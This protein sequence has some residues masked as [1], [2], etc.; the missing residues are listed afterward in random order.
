MYDWLI[1]NNILAD[2]L[3]QFYINNLIVFFFQINP[4]IKV[5]SFIKIALCKKAVTDFPLCISSLFIGWQVSFGS[6]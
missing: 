4:G 5:I 1:Y 2:S 6:C 3:L